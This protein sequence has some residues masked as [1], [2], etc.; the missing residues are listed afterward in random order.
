MCHRLSAVRVALLTE[1]VDRNPCG[2]GQFKQIMKV[3]LLTEGVDRNSNVRPPVR[4]ALVALLTE[5]VDRNLSRQI[6]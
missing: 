3:A 2:V 6:L 1:G 5:G 4:V